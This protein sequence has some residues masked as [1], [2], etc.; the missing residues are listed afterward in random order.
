M[1]KKSPMAT[2]AEIVQHVVEGDVNAFE[3]LLKRHR[4]YILGIVRKHVPY[5]EVEETIQEVFIRA[6]KSLL[7]FKGKSEFKYWLSSI[8]ARTCSDYWR[9]AYRSQEVPLS[10][11]SEKHRNWLEGA[12]SDQSDRTYQEAGSQQEAKE[13]LAWALGKLSPK[14]RMVLEMVYLEGLSGKET[15]D[16]LGWSHANVKVRSHRSRKK[17]KK[18]IEDVL[19]P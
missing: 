11:L 14:D 7:T 6:Y 15:A 2:D 5:Q 18:I 10:S 17:L 19:E 12:L 3:H 8:A 13:L 16:L 1:Q 9:K 4:D